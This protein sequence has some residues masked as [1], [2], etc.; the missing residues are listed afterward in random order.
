LRRLRFGSEVKVFFGGSQ[1][2]V[3]GSDD[4]I[5]FT[6]ASEAV[7]EWRVALQQ[8]VAA[9]SSHL[10]MGQPTVKEGWVQKPKKEGGWSDR[11]A[12]LTPTQLELRRSPH[13]NALSHAVAVV[14]SSVRVAGD[15]LTISLPQQTNLAGSDKTVIAFASREA[16]EW[17]RVIRAQQ[18]ELDPTAVRLPTGPPVSR[19]GW[20]K[21]P[22]KQGGWSDRYAVLTDTTIALRRSPAPNSRERSVCLSA[23]EVA[24]TA[25]QRVVHVVGEGGEAVAFSLA[26]GRGREKGVEEWAEAVRGKVYTE[27]EGD[28]VAQSV[29]EVSP[30][31]S[32]MSSSSPYVHPSDQQSSYPLSLSRSP[33]TPPSPHISRLSVSDGPCLFSRPPALPPGAHSIRGRQGL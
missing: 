12:V 16:E 33:R 32:N 19:E 26:A 18:L 23:A 15:V 4:T 31:S 11:Y 24:V 28:Q 5:I 9:P 30:L 29:L 1:V 7:E 3:R 8:V 6:A 22:R 20:V 25:D 14:A 13:Q 2:E 17:G 21:K 27:A 10:S